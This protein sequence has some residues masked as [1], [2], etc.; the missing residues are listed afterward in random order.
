MGLSVFSIPSLANDGIMMYNQSAND[1]IW[2]DTTLTE[3]SEFQTTPHIDF[4]IRHAQT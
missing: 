4:V 2:T 1:R 3:L